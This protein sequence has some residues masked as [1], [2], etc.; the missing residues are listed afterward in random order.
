LGVASSGISGSSVSSGGGG[1]CFIAATA[2]SSLFTRLIFYVLLNLALVVLG[3]Y[4][5][6]KIVRRRYIAI[7]N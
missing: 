6:E 2:S 3:I 7:K 1:G 4:T 5:F